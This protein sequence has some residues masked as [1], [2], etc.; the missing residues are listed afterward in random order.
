MILAYFATE[1]FS[2]DNSFFCDNCK[3]KSSK[4]IKDTLI[5]KLPPILI[6][7]INRFKYDKKEGTKKK[8]FKSVKPYFSFNLKEDIFPDLPYQNNSK[9]L[10]YYLYGILIHSVLH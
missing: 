9:E 2:Q 10:E 7:S 3:K 4:A 6:L 5:I 1:E 8:L